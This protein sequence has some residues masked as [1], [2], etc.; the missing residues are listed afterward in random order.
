MA[1]QSTANK[2]TA[3]QIYTSQARQ[4]VRAGVPKAEQYEVTPYSSTAQDKAEKPVQAGIQ[5]PTGDATLEA[6]GYGDKAA[7]VAGNGRE[8]GVVY[9]P[10]RAAVPSGNGN[11]PQSPTS[12]SSVAAA[13]AANVGGSGVT[14]SIGD[15]QQISY[16]DEINRMYDANLAARKAE[17][18]GAYQQNLSNLEANRENIA[19]TY[20]RQRNASAADYERQ[21]RNFNEQAMMNGL[22]TGTGSQANLAMNAAQQKA[23]GGLLASEASDVS[24]LE[25]SIANLKTQYQSDINSAIADN[26][27]K[28]AAALLDEYNNAYSRNMQQAQIRAQY[29]DFSGYAALY[30]REAAVQMASVWARQNPA[31]AYSMGMIDAN[32]YAQLTG[33]S[34]GGSR[35]GG[36][37]SANTSDGDAFDPDAFAKALADAQGNTT[38]GEQPAASTSP[39]SSGSSKPRVT[40]GATGLPWDRDAAGN[41]FQIW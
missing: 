21:R 36:G 31:I 32:T 37:S 34:T 40:I 14:P 10:N 25:R 7:N 8:S 39:S 20:Q 6:L 28:R 33:R 5:K 1:L 11:V 30:G 12:S 19:K 38:T 41:S 29:G 27:Y 2:Q 3:Q 15:A 35:G 26:D 23:Q 18:E 16:A 9:T 24:N 17:L 13:Y 4:A 22:N